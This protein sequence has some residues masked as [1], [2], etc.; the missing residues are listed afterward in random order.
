MPCVEFNQFNFWGH[1]PTMTRTI[2]LNPSCKF[3]LI[4]TGFT[5][6][7]LVYLVEMFRLFRLKWVF[8]FQNVDITGG[9]SEK[10]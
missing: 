7:E 6:G 8:C 4:N 3:Y 10:I 1:A 5:L 9:L 2:T